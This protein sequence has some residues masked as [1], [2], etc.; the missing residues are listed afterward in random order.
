MRSLRMLRVQESALRGGNVP[1]AALGG[2]VVLKQG[3]VFLVESAEGRKSVLKASDEPFLEAAAA[4]VGRLAG[5]RTIDAVPVPA[6][7]GASLPFD[8]P[9]GAWLLQLPW[10]DAPTLALATTLF[11]ARELG[12]VWAFDAFIDNSDRLIK[13]GNPRNL[14]VEHDGS[15]VALDQRL[16]PTV[17]GHDDPV[18]VTQRRLR[19]VATNAV[20]EQVARDLF[21]DFRREANIRVPDREAH[22]RAFSLGVREGIRRIASLQPAALSGA[23]PFPTP[24]FGPILQQF[25]EVNS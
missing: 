16:G 25:R 13:G 3:R 9:R 18:R 11:D 1:R 17:L 21:D 5:V 15:L 24:G 19:R 20:R 12:Q 14:L 10:I 23:C 7:R 2:T 22:A 4:A 6:S 8:E